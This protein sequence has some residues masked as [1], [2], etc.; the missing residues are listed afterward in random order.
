MPETRTIKE[1]S[2]NIANSKNPFEAYQRLWGEQQARATQAR[3]NYTPEQRAS[4]DWTKTLKKTEGKYNEPII[5]YDD[6]IANSEAK[7]KGLLE[8]KKLQKQV[9][10][11]T[12]KIP[13]LGREV[14]HPNKTYYLGDSGKV[15]FKR[16]NGTWRETPNANVIEEVNYVA[17]NGKKALLDRMK[18]ED[19]AFN[20]KQTEKEVAEVKK[21]DNFKSWFKGSKI[22]DERGEPLV[23]YHGTGSDISE[24]KPAF[25]GS[26]ND[27]YGS[28]YYFTDKADIANYYT[29]KIGEVATDT[30]GN[31]VGG[32]NNPNIMPVFL[33]IKKPIVI[34]ETN[35]DFEQ[36]T[37]I[38]LEQI[39]KIIE[40]SH[41]P[42]YAL[43]DFGDISYDGYNKVLDDA[44]RSYIDTGDL[45]VMNRLS[46]QFFNG[47]EKAFN[48]IFQEV[49]GYD[50]VKIKLEGGTNFVA[51]NP[52]QIKSVNNKG[53][54]SKTDPNILNSSPT[55]SGGIVGGLVGGANDPDQDG[56]VTWKDF[57]IGAAVGAGGT[58]LAM[59]ASD[60][61]SL[62][63]AKTKLKKAIN[64]DFV[65]AFTGHKI[66]AKK[67]YMKVR[68]EM[69]AGKNA[70]M[71]D[72]AQLHE[73]LALLSDA[74]KTNIH[75]YMSGEK[76]ELSPA[77]KSFADDYTKQI[78]K[79]GQELVDLGVLDAAQYNKF[80]GRYLHRVYEK[81]LTK[82]IK[83][84][85]SKGKTIQG[86]HT[87]GNEWT[88]T[89]A[90]F[91][92]LT[93]EGQIGDFFDG[94]IEARKL[95][96]GQ[97]KFTQD[98]TKQQREKWGEVKDIAYTLPETLMRMNDM[99]QHGKMLDKVSKQTDIVS[100]EAIDGFTHLQGKRFGA[101]QGKYVPKDVASDI[102][103]FNK[104]MFGSEDGTIFSA[105]VVDAYKAASTFWK[106]SHTVYNPTAHMNNL[107]S[108]VT[109]QYMEGINPATALKNSK[110]G[111]EAHAKLGEFRKLTAK[112]LIG[113][114]K[115]EETKLAALTD[116]TDLTLYI[117]ANDAGLFGR[118]KLNDILGQYVK[119]DQKKAKGVL[120]KLD[121]VTSNMYQGEDNIMRFSLLKSLVDQGKNF[122]DAIKQVNNTIPDYT[123]PMSRMA[124][125]G[126]A[127][128]LTPFISWTYYSTPI[129]LRQM[130]ER[131]GRAAALAGSLYA[132]NQAMGI[133]PYDKKD[134]PQQNF[135]MKRIPVYKNGNEVS[136]IKVDRWMPHNEI[137]SPH[138]FIKNLYNG[139]AWK[140]GYE[141][142]NNQN[143]YYGG[144]IS[145]NEGARKAYDI[146]KHGVQQITPDALDKVW[147]LAESQIL[148]KKQ[149]T[150]NPVIQP[151]STVQ[152]TLGFLGLNTLTYNK[153]NQ[154]RKVN[155]EKL[156]K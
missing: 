59:K 142:L 45:E 68:E 86:V 7:P 151:R 58:K 130:K 76:A 100:D 127:S 14:V 147:N 131:P 70:K 94:K 113:L 67:D 90:E 107:L 21:D 30:R 28:G 9:D 114:S 26:G 81:D 155:N 36:A 112:K 3:M 6:G 97:Y 72:F 116:D 126:R 156:K 132:I 69:I 104:T 65:D 83:T 2:E 103:E 56:K 63:G 106:K 62:A 149:R 34:D 136:T 38:T 119:P 105:E 92:R 129:V 11:A 137:L 143:L 42:K 108:N 134:I 87:R 4:E 122:D 78:E 141:V 121:D 77:L 61:V 95:N 40:K 8:K 93:K 99:L 111:Y 19:E 124:R 110:R 148:S 144:K 89:K 120:G 140:G 55:V 84:A 51:L 31:Q 123:K 17:K 152:E 128:M 75:K 102:T 135:S 79:M 27:Q 153:A 73:Q 71:E 12:G 60:S 1:W 101:L 43:S 49:T 33:D 47:E 74:A 23:V 139:G 46:L 146:T 18:A 82:S 91:D 145:Y 98:W 15:Y 20:A 125:F 80:K 37:N 29:G 57:A 13:E 109:M 66:Y 22:I 41:K 115:A 52:T 35:I 64:T 96:N 154:R 138:D 53:T 39:K 117:Q 54:F 133:D 48:K 85:F 5:K 88:G 25:I 118:S 50:G 32:T 44:A 24:F 10:I 16:A 150:K